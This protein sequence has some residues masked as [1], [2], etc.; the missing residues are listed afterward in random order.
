[1]DSISAVRTLTRCIPVTTGCMLLSAALGAG[2]A[3]PVPDNL[4]PPSGFTRVLQAEASGVQIYRCKARPTSGA[5]AAGAQGV[6]RLEA[7]RANLTDAQGTAIRHYAGPTWEASDGSKVT[8]KVIAS[9]NAPQ[10][11]AVAWLLL[12]A[13]PAG[14]S[15]RLA[16]VR[17]VQRLYTS[18]GKAPKTACDR[19]GE[20]LEVPYRATY[21]FWAP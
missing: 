10:P 5:G 8:G 21:V 6:W 4:A 1:M 18:G 20:T 3:D 14:G 16:R 7:P 9:A 13:E 12:S 17:A 15:G 2:A 19:I 11:D